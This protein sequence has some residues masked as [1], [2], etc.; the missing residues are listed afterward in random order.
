MRIHSLEIANFRGIEHLELRDLPDT[1]V[2]V[3]HG[4]N[5]AGKSTILDAV[6][7]VLRERSSAK[8]K[9]IKAVA[10]VGR[11]AAPA[12]TLSATVGDTSFT[13]R[14]HWLKSPESVL[15]ITAPQRRTYTG[16]E[17]DD[18]LERI[19]SEHMDRELAQNLFLRQGQLDPGIQ[20]AGIPSIAA[21][22]QDRSGGE[23]TAA[24]DTELMAAVEREYA[25]YFTAGPKPKEKASYAAKF[26]AVDEA[27]AAYDRARREVADLSSYVDEVA[28]RE[29]EIRSADA[30]MP[31]ANE[32][33]A[34]REAEAVQARELG[35]KAQRS[36]EELSRAAAALERAEE[37]VAARDQLTQRVQTLAKE[38]DDLR[39]KLEPAR[40][41]AEQEAAK[42]ADLTRALEEAKAAAARA[43]TT[44]RLAGKRRDLARAA[45]DLH[46]K[47]ELIER[48]EEADTS[49]TSLL[50]KAPRREVT[51]KDIRSLEAA[52]SDVALQRRLLDAAAAKLDITAPGRTISVDGEQREVTG[53]SSVGVFEGTE[54]V[55]GDFTVVYRAAQ[56][57]EDPR[58]AVRKAEE[59]LA[60]LIDAT[61]YPSIAA[62]RTARDE[63]KEHAAAFKA[64]KQRRADLLAGSDLETL[65]AERTALHATVT[66]LAAELDLDTD[67]V[68]ELTLPDTEHA[69]REAETALAEAE[70][71]VDSTD[72]AVKPYADRKAANELT[73]LETRSE[74]KDAERDAAQAELDAAEE[75]HPRDAMKAVLETVRADMVEA[76]KVHDDLAARSAAADP[77]LAERLLQGATTRVE[78]LQR[79][80]SDAENRIRELAGRIDLAAGAAEKADQ[81]EAELDKAETELQRA[82]RRAEAARLLRETM[83]THRDAAR[84]RY[85]APFNE[86]LR[87]HARVIY[88]SSVDFNFG[89]SLEITE[90]TVDGTTVPLSELS[91][92]TKEQLAIL[93]RFAIADLVTGTGST[94]PV[95][96]VVD[97]ALGA[98]DPDRLSRMNL[99]FDQVGQNAQV[100]VMTCFPSRFDRVNAARRYAIAE[101]KSPGGGA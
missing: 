24:E 70:R 5:E 9:E 98:T 85:T 86:A 90:R 89:D 61:G 58:E 30:E 37:D 38:A 49:Y 19:L 74:T 67:A 88:G 8:K 96:V 54:V 10:P 68:A 99:L 52:E 18:Q 16:R 101:L 11:D 36:R 84:A 94:S 100:I 21:A 45:N 25:K 50:Q 78:N 65:R 91:G 56:G 34:A 93:T 20:A 92:G 48:A 79:R 76:K 46:A 1:G 95:P 40:E 62:A 6:D 83:V 73:V 35:Q 69:L 81:A 87:N 15:E 27:K 72:A 42:L 55:L 28:R 39:A 32:E 17:A 13:I 43:R 66:E 33:A 71:E 60:L 80:K 22:L 97:D 41:A 29:E 59:K 31:E 26:T 2:I 82:T 44:V 7:L 53:T 47:D 63:H 3:I 75:K 57:S 64:A 23:P 77:E 12:V 14:K 4:D 51:D